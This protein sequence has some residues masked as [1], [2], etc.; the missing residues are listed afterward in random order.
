MTQSRPDGSLK[1]L[2]VRIDGIGD[3]VCITPLLAALRARH[4]DAR[5]DV[6]A[7]EYN[8]DVLQRNPH[9][10]H[11]YIDYRTRDR[12]SDRRS[13]KR[14]LL[15]LWQNLRLRA[16]GYDY[17]IVAHFGEHT[18]ALKIA[19]QV[20]PKTT[21]R[22][23][24]P[25]KQGKSEP[26]VITLAAIWGRHEVLGSFELLKPLGIE[27]EPGPL[28]VVPDA[29]KLATARQHMQAFRE[30]HALKRLIGLNLSVSAPTR[31]WPAEKFA[32]LAQTV[33]QR[34]PDSGFVLFWVNDAPYGKQRSDNQ[35]VTLLTAQ[36]NTIAVLPF[37]THDIQDLIAGLAGCDFVVS[38]DGGPLHIAA[39]LGK[40]VLGFFERLDAKL[41]RWYPWQVPARVLCNHVEHTIDVSEITLDQAVDGLVDLVREVENHAVCS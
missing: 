13:P 26:S 9:V 3:L 33:A 18:R 37:A 1:F 38:S 17:A 23:I 39:G 21:I 28:L 15:K 10:D 41:C 24:E 31:A 12:V 35:A 22:S 8:A 5:I 11:V 14:A 40:P 20:R 25:E 4:P 7:N 2:I 19:H 34:L 36:S 32:Q 30:Q 6:M 27:Q 16:V 29:D